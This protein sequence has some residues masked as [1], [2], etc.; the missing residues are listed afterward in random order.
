MDGNIFQR[1]A[2][3][4][5]L[6]Y[7]AWELSRSI[8]ICVMD[9]R[10]DNNLF[11]LLELID[12]FVNGRI[13]GQYWK[14]KNIRKSFKDVSSIK[15]F[16]SEENLN[17][18]DF[19]IKS[20]DEG[21]KIKS[22][23]GTFFPSGLTSVWYP[24]R[25]IECEKR[26][27][28]QTRMSL[29]SQEVGRRWKLRNGINDK[30]S[31]LEF[32]VGFDKDV[33]MEEAYGII[34]GVLTKSIPKAVDVTTTGYIGFTTGREFGLHSE[35]APY[36]KAY[37]LLKEKL[38]KPYHMIFGRQELFA[39]LYEVDSKNSLLKTPSGNFNLMYFKEE[40]EDITSKYN[41]CFIEF[42][43]S[44]RNHDKFEE[45]DIVI[46]D[47]KIGVTRK[48]LKELV[49]QDRIW[50]GDIG[51]YKH[52]IFHEYERTE[53][54]DDILYLCAEHLIQRYKPEIEQL[55]D[56]AIDLHIKVYEKYFAFNSRKEQILPFVE[57]Y[58][59][60]YFNKEQ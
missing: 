27:D 47:K 26:S 6:K 11:N 43:D 5:S 18:L 3:E 56:N 10:L 46:G 35:I 14:G 15:T 22:V 1:L 34:Y 16:L 23:E 41:A 39:G 7:P 33:T 54:D 4:N 31:R 53:K 44:L 12:G 32:H 48:R 36:P 57:E 30:P 29:R 25:G 8:P 52:L 28:E 55:V 40:L 20:K 9:F 59:R 21:A 37:E 49:E 2:Y 17:F 51:R 38:A 58:V 19:T 13:A 45:G 42:N 50:E 24:I 60:N